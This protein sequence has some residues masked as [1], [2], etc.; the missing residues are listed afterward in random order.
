M[1]PLPL[2]RRFVSALPYR[3]GDRCQRCGLSNWIIGR[4]TA[5][6]AGCSAAVPLE[7]EVAH[8]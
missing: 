8:V 1:T 4:V 3:A 5:E 6:C 2:P 7:R